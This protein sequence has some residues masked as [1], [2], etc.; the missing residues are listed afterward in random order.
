MKAA[1]IIYHSNA[2]KIYKQEWIDKCVNSIMNQ[3]YKGADIFELNYGNC[4]KHFTNGYKF[5]VPM[6][7]HISAM[8]YLIAM[9]LSRGYDVI[10]NVNLDDYYSLDR[11]DAQIAAINKGAQLVSSNF[12]YFNDE[13]GHFKRMDMQRY[14][15][16]GVQFRRNHNPIAHPVVAYHKSF[17]DGGLQYDNLLGYEDLDLWKKAWEL[18]KRIVILPE[19]LL[20]YRIHENQITKTYKGL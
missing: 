19:Y 10:F 12:H 2:L 14:S 5:T 15:N 18:N 17:F 20:H 9:V 8:N 4:G 13:R 7:N 11:F 3:T 1:V 16:L 6:K